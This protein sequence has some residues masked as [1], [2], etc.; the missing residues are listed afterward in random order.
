MSEHEQMVRDFTELC[1]LMR[2]VPAMLDRAKELGWLCERSS[3]K[4]MELEQTKC[5]EDRMRVDA[6]IAK[7]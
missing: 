6:M 2:E 3:Q 4:E 7:L 1:A 5:A